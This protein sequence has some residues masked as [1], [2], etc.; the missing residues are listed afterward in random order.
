MRGLVLAEVVGLQGVSE[1][2]RL[3]ESERKPLSRNRI[4]ASRSVSD[5]RH[6]PAVNMRQLPCHGNRAAFGVGQR[7]PF[8]ARGKFWELR[9]QQ[10]EFRFA[11]LRHQHD[12][13][14]ILNH[15]RHI[16]LR[17][18]APINFHELGP[19]RHAVVPTHGIPAIVA[20]RR[21]ETGPLAHA[22]AYAIRA[23]NPFC[24][25][26]PSG[27][28]GAWVGD[29]YDGSVPEQGHPASPRS[30]DQ[31]F[32]EQWPPHSDSMAACEIR[33][34]FVLSPIEANSVQPVSFGPA[35]RNAQFG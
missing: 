30:F 13:N 16:R 23:D 4:H 12:A 17:V 2:N 21:F 27:K 11:V 32:V 25:E 33:A 6:P 22:R 20:R 29:P 26:D 19:R 15:W 18:I 9:F 31:F 35:D 8:Q 5:Q 14:L 1:R 34:G 24:R 28:F 7:G 3:P 10:I